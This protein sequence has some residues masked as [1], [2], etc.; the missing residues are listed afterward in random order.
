MT[1]TI[2]LYCPLA[3]SLNTQASIVPST[4]PIWTIPQTWPLWSHWVSLA[5]TTP[6]KAE[7]HL[8]QL[9]FFPKTFFFPFFFEAQPQICLE[10]RRGPGEAFPVTLEITTQ[11]SLT[12]CSQTQTVHLTNQRVDNVVRV[13]GAGGRVGVHVSTFSLKLARAITNN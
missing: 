5:L 3:V 2:F 12:V 11:W 7:S 9:I 1:S 13:D 10:L 4:V 8:L 6:C